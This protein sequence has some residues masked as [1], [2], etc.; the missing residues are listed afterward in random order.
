[1][2]ADVDVVVVGVALVA[3]ERVRGGNL[4]GRQ[5]RREA[6]QLDRLL[7]QAP[8]VKVEVE[9]VVVH[10]VLPQA[11]QPLLGA[12]LADAREPFQLAP[13][14]QARREDVRE[15]ERKHQFRKDEDL[16]VGERRRRGFLFIANRSHVSVCV[17]SFVCIVRPSIPH[18]TRGT[19]QQYIISQLRAAAASQSFS[20][21][22]PPAY[23]G[24]S[25]PRRVVVLH[26]VNAQ[27]ARD[28][29]AAH[30][31]ALQVRHLP[32]IGLLIE[33][34]SLPPRCAT[35]RP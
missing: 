5:E 30:P 23:A 32:E 24:C 20:R 9:G 27:P 3:E 13:P 8:R 12:H 34:A 14:P 18:G 26:T 10:D 29:V 33:V 2:A 31:I 25:R 7:R 1:M 17:H 22:R 11:L 28:F 15:H 4:L 19:A 16:H 35:S 21:A 6:L